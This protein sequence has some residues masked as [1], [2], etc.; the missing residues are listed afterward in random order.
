METKKKKKKRERSVKLK[1]SSLRRK[2]AN[3]SQ[4]NQEKKKEFKSIKLRMKKG[5]V[6]MNTMEAQRI[7]DYYELIYAN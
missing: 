4:I 3:F 1:A 5:D 2:L 7:R 6:T